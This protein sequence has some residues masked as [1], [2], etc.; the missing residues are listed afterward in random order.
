MTIKQQLENS[1]KDAM[2][3]SD[4]VR[5]RTLRMALSS[6]KMAEIEKRKPLDDPAT[7]AILQ[8]EIK[9][10]NEAI[11]EARRAHRSDLESAAQDEISVLES[12]LP[13]R[14]TDFELQDAVKSVMA[15]INAT[16]PSDM[17]RIIKIVM[18]RY[19]FRITG[20]RVSQVVRS[21]LEK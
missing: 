11:Q 12:F 14:L 2:R 15:E 4:D 7:M 20:D 17:G 5:R 19:P 8:N 9:S 3:A 1:L 13:A 6:I 10:R 18:E 16:S 21:L